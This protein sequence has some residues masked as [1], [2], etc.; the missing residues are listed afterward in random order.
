MDGGAAFGV[1]GDWRWGDVGLGGV[2]GG[3]GGKEVVV[4]VV[5][6]GEFGGEV[7]RER[8]GSVGGELG[9]VGGDLE[10]E[11]EEGFAGAGHG[12]G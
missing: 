4:E 1:Y 3:F 5:E 10:R 7:R 2:G 11:E 6:G 9:G 8:T 12:G